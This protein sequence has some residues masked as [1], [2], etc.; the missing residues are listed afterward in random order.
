MHAHNAA[1]DGAATTSTGLSGGGRDCPNCGISAADPDGFAC[2]YCRGYAHRPT[3]GPDAVLAGMLPVDVHADIILR[4][5]EEGSILT[6]EAARDVA[7][8]DG[9]GGLLYAV[10]VRLSAL[11]AFTDERPLTE[12][13][14]CGDAMDVRRLEARALPTTKGLCSECVM[15]PVREARRVEREMR[16]AAFGEGRC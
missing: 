10:N 16:V 7:N 15:H 5:R 4:A 9:G 6:D 2:D 13:P 8:R 14:G 11:R 12:C 3:N 1:M